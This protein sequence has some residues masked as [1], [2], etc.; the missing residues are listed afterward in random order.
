MQKVLKTVLKSVTCLSIIAIATAAFAATDTSRGT[1]TQNRG[2]G[3][4]AARMP[5]I[6]I[7]P[8]SAGGNM[9]VS[10]NDIDPKPTPQPKPTPNPTPTPEP[11]PDPDTPVP[12]APN[13]PTPQTQCADGGV[14]NS[15]YTVDNCM[16][17]ILGCVNGGALPNGIN[18]LFNEDLRNSIVNGMGLCLTQVEH[19]VTTV[20]RNCQY[21]YASNSDVW[22]DFNARKVQPEYYAFV[23]R[24]TG[25]TPTQAENTCLLLDRNTYGAAFNAVSVGDS[26]TSE[27][28]QRVGAYNS[29]RNDSLSK[30]NPLGARVNDTG[31][32]GKRGYYARW[33]AENAQCLLRV[34][35]Y[36]K[37]TPITN[38][39]LF[40]I[41][42]D[43]SLAEVWQATGSSFTCNKDLFGFSLM[44]KTKTVAAT[45]IPGGTL[46]GAGIGAL[47]GH[48]DRNFDCTIESMRNTLLKELQDNQKI[49]A[50]NQ[51]ISS[52][53]SSTSKS[54]TLGQCREIV[55]LYDMWE[56]GKEAVNTCRDTKKDVKE[57]EM[58]TVT[59]T[60][61]ITCEAEVKSD[62]SYTLPDI[63]AKAILESVEKA[64]N[65]APCAC[66]AVAK[67]NALAFNVDGD[68]KQEDILQEIKNWYNKNPNA[69]SNCGGGNT[70][71]TTTETHECKFVNLNQSWRDGTDVYCSRS[72]ECLGKDEF[73]RQLDALDKIFNSVEILAGEKGNRLKTTLVGA[74]IGAATGGT[75]TAITAFVEKNNINCRVADG[76][77]KVGLGKSYTIDRLRDFYVKWALNLPSTI[78]PTAVVTNCDNWSLTCALFTDTKECTNAKFNYRPGN[79]SSTTLITNPC[80]PSGSACIA[81]VS[82]A[83]ANG[84]CLVTPTPTPGSDE[85]DPN[86][87]FTR[88]SDCDEWINACKL[89]TTE[90][91]CNAAKVI[92][93]P[94]SM[95]VSNACKYNAT[96]RECRPRKA[97]A[98][99]YLDVTKCPI[100]LE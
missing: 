12:P 90:A 65:K 79:L 35:A 29:A 11:E 50:I 7:L 55:D 25:L 97:K 16:N 17:D 64:C 72:T 99:Q 86:A 42:G 93:V 28:D 52:D 13:P 82:V 15:S 60:F 92:Y 58:C 77:A 98:E 78:A 1:A 2:R 67:Q 27:Y 81:N 75:A 96:A 46:L 3:T 10:S 56:M 18:S 47:A 95:R 14:E 48:G 38:S 49:G 84:A 21:V 80:V 66:E 74:G 53:L 23:L 34:A 91:N 5:S 39:W 20:R 8:V 89:F 19:C 31:I 24:Q 71:S 68:C 22:L 73:K 43:D 69:C 83:Q 45:A 87:A 76:L 88:V 41:V 54:M 51:Y 100:R 70:T 26:V 30:L 44:P 32:D 94:Q 33:D 63:A 59:T 9:T 40:G 6:P 61:D 4:A 57:Q 85:P 37:D 36:N 62:G